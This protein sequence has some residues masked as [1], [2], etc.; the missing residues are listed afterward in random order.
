VHRPLSVLVAGAGIAGPALAYWLKR[1]GHR[2]V[3]V[4]RMDLGEAVRDARTRIMTVSVVR[5]D[6]R[7]TYDV[8]LRPLHLARG[9]QEIE[10]MRADLVRILFDAVAEDTEVVFG[11]AV[12]SVGQGEKSIGVGFNRR[13]SSISSGQPTVSIRRCARWPSGPSAKMSANTVPA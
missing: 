8:P 6:G 10:G 1:R 13:V 7:N 3:L 5:S 2:P 9:D 12:R 4:E 11:D